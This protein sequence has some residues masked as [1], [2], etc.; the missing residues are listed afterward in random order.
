MGKLRHGG[1][2]GRGSLLFVPGML[3]WEEAFFPQAFALPALT[4]SITAL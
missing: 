4:N 3:R 1:G 2:Q